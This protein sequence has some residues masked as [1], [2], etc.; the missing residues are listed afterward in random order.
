M[1]HLCSTCTCTQ[2]VEMFAR[3]H[4]LEPWRVEGMVYYSTAL[5]HLRRDTVCCF[6]LC[7]VCLHVA[8]NVAYAVSVD[9]TGCTYLQELAALAQRMQ[10]SHRLSPDACL[11]AG[12]CFSLQKDHE[13]ALKFFRRVRV[14][15]SEWCSA[16]TV[17]LFQ[18]T[19]TFVS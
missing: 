4:R 16:R 2:S 1:G 14:C 15:V 17:G 19:S 9:L 11:I 18:S 8:S 10:G 13:T 6:V 7:A 3:A 5:W 12:N